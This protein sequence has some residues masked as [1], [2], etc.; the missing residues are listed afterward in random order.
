MT[1][2][3]CPIIIVTITSN[4]IEIIIIINTKGSVD[5]WGQTILASLLHA[6]FDHF[7]WKHSY[8]DDDDDDSGGGDGDGIYC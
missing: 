6:C 2:T 1:T 7:W 8:D 5:L 3:T 4:I